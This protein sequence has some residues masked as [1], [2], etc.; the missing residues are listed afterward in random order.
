MFCTVGS[1]GQYFDSA[2]FGEEVKKWQDDLA[3]N[4]DEVPEH[5][6]MEDSE[7]QDSFGGAYGR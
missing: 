2:A 7:S 5:V 1:G 4:P 6:G 3:M